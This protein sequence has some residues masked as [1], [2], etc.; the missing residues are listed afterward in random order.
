MA[1]RIHLVF[2]SILFGILLQCYANESTLEEV[3]VKHMKYIFLF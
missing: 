2:A 3:K 1:L